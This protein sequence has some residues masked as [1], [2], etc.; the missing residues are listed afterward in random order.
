VLAQKI[1]AL[2]GAVGWQRFE[3][4]PQLTK[5]MDIAEQFMTLISSSSG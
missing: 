3:L 2:P 1:A 5:K 4:S